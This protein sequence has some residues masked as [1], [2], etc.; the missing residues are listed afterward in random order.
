MTRFI[1]T[2]TGK[3][4]HKKENLPKNGKSPVGKLPTPKCCY[5]KCKEDAIGS[6]SVDIDIRGMPYCKKHKKDVSS[7]LLWLILGV[8]EL[9]L[10]ALG[11][12]QKKKKKVSQS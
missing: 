11:F 10:T 9:S 8:E 2:R 6:Y 4:V 1:K 12:P 7:S 5:N 3:K